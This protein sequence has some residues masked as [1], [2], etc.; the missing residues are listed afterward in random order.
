MAFRGQ[1]GGARARVRL[2]LVRVCL[3]ERMI[4]WVQPPHASGRSRVW[5][6]AALAARIQGP[7]R[8]SS[9][10]ACSSPL[11]AMCSKKYACAASL[12]LPPAAHASHEL[13]HLNA[14]GAV[15]GLPVERDDSVFHA[16]D[17]RV[18][19]ISENENESLGRAAG[20]HVRHGTCQSQPTETHRASLGLA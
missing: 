8:A 12:G 1:S 15:D 10:S 13:A 6:H 16:R 18:D 17:F 2:K 19:S 11:G 20:S 9:L 14:F 5:V 4:R 3:C 7:A